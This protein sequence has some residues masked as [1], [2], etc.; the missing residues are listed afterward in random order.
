MQIYILDL[1]TDSLCYING[2][3]IEASFYRLSDNIQKTWYLKPT[4]YETIS[5]DALRI[6]G[7]KLEDLKHETKFGRD[8]YIEP[9][10]AI[11]EIENWIMEDGCQTSERVI[12]GHNPTFDRN[13]LQQLWAKNNCSD[14]F[15]FGK[16]MIDT[17][18]IALIMD[19]V[20]ETKR[21][22]YSLISLA[23]DFGVKIEKA[24]RADAD[25][26]MTK[27][28]FL[29]QIDYLKKIFHNSNLKETKDKISDKKK[30]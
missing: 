3:I 26:R 18:Q 27:D 24:H 25:T 9:S 10:K 15:P 8:T 20:N 16:R 4:N 7:H 22:S 12:V 19:M 14:S 6:N 5:A 11:V 17:L 21:D 2:E 29:N 23:K 13:F 1:E 30:I 28:L